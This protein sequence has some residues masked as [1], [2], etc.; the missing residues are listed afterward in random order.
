MIP[1]IDLLKDDQMVTMEFYQTAWDGSGLEK[2]VQLEIDIAIRLN[3][4]EN[5]CVLKTAWLKGKLCRR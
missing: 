1:Y 2:M 3:K 4:F 5:V